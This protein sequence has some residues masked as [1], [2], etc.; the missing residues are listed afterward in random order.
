MSKV[1]VE[2]GF[3]LLESNNLDAADRECGRGVPA[4]SGPV[5]SHVAVI[6]Q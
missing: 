4:C 2:D 5:T 3:A 6:L 1:A